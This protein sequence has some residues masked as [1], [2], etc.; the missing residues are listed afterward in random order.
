MNIFTIYRIKFI[1]LVILLNFKV[2][3]FSQ[4]FDP[5]D[6]IDLP[7][8]NSGKEIIAMANEPICPK[9]SLK[10]FAF[11]HWDFGDGHSSA[12]EFP[13]HTYSKP[14]TY[15]VNVVGHEACED[16]RKFEKLFIHVLPRET[17]NKLILIPNPAK[18]K[19]LIKV[20]IEDTDPDIRLEVVK[21]HSGLIMHSYHL[22]STE[23]NNNTLSLDIS[24]YQQGAYQVILRNGSKLISEEKLMVLQ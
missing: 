18:D 22:V 24:T 20:L 21:T 14:G 10:Y 8:I 9:S 12:D 1:S 16:A 11:Y 15:E 2:P 17:G 3:A 5:F 23:L 6:C 4:D 7:P 13:C 19:V